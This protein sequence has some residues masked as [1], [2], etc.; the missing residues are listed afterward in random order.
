MIE[1]KDQDRI[2]EFSSEAVLQQ[3]L[4]GLLER[5]PGIERVQILH[6]QQEYGKDIVFW[7]TGPIGES[8]PCACV[9]KNGRI[10]GSADS[11]SGARTVL[12]QVEQALDTPFL[13]ESGHRTR[14][15]RVYVYSPF[16]IN[17]TTL[18]SI[19]GRLAQRLGQVH[20]VGGAQLFQQ[21]RNFWPDY[22]ADEA[23]AL[24]KHLQTLQSAFDDTN[25]LAEICFDFGIGKLERPDQRIYVEQRLELKVYGY[26]ICEELRNPVPVVRQYDMHDKRSAVKC[27]EAGELAIESLHVLQDFFR[28]CKSWFTNYGTDGNPTD[29]ISEI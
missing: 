26:E 3:A 21:F 15:Y 4:V 16:E 1:N 6:G 7:A 5:M 11:S 19:E 2:A 25:A 24:E 14:I 8:I 22:F 10:S 20:F 28:H 29:L 12:H 17:Q 9:V 13:D 23:I 18:H 27:R